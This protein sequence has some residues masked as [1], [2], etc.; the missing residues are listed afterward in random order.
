MFKFFFVAEHVS[1]QYC[2]VYIVNKIK[3]LVEHGR[4][5]TAAVRPDKS[6]YYVCYTCPYHTN[7]IS[8]M[9]RHAYTHY[10]HKFLQCSHCSYKCSNYSHMKRH[11]FTHSKEKPLV[12]LFCEFK[13]SRKDYLKVHFQKIHDI[14]ESNN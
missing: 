8:N 6:Y 5:C 2:G 3:I 11:N 10:G 1:C 4:E 13:T 9:K 7:E 14:G 12:C